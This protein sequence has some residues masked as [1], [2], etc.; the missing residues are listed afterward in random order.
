MDSKIDIVDKW[1]EKLV[2]PGEVKDFV[3][4]TKN[5]KSE[6]VFHKEYIFYTDEYKYKILAIDRPDDGG[7]LGCLVSSRKPRAGEDWTRGNDLPDG[8]LEEQTWFMILNAIINYELVE[9]SK[10]KRPDS[11]PE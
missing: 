8:P 3:K 1:I 7:Y 10:Y 5:F 4:T 9:L 6:G 2:F 11:V